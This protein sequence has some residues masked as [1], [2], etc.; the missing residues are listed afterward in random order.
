MLVLDAVGLLQSSDLCAILIQVCEASQT[1]VKVI[2]CS[3][4]RSCLHLT[5][6]RLLQAS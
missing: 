4:L 6:A 3:V 2:R 1:H 5:V